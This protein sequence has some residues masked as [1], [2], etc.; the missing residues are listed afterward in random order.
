MKEEEFKTAKADL[1]KKVSALLEKGKELETD[2]KKLTEST[3]KMWMLSRWRAKSAMKG[4]Q[5][6]FEVNCML[7]EREFQKL[8]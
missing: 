8:D 6:Q 7:A 5:H 1:A 3:R 4:V 2:K